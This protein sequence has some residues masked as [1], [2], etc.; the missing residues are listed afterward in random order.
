MNKNNILKA[1]WNWSPA[2]WSMLCVT[3]WKHTGLLPI[4][5]IGWLISE[6]ITN[7]GLHQELL[8][9]FRQ[10]ESNLTKEEIE[11]AHRKWRKIKRKFKDHPNESFKD[12]VSEK[13]YEGM[14]NASNVKP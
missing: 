4:G 11:Q 14:M 3:L 5:F 13:L 7:R 1:L 2:Q 8:R 10:F 9:S 6:Q 12:W